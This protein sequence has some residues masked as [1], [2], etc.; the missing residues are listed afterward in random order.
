MQSETSCYNEYTRSGGDTVLDART[1]ISMEPDMKAKLEKIAKE[2]R[3]SLS[4]LVVKEM[5]RF[6]KR[7]EEENGNVK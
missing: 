6:L 5:D 2:D 4:S 1:M 7:Y 3:R